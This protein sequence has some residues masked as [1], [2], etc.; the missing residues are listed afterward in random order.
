MN[1]CHDW[2]L[3][4]VALAMAPLALYGWLVFYDRHV[5]WR[6]RLGLYRVF[7]VPPPEDR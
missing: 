2:R 3:F 6:I 7:R 5:G 4:G 1:E